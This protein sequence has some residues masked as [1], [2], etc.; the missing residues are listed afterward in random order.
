MFMVCGLLDPVGLFFGGL[1]WWSP[2]PWGCVVA[3]GGPAGFV[4]FVAHVGDLSF[5]AS[6][7]VYLGE[8]R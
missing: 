5:V 7:R 1:L 8:S 4:C 2:R 3:L 6:V